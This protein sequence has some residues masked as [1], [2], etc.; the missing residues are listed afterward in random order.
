MKRR[1]AKADRTPAARRKLVEIDAET[2]HGLDLLARD[3]FATFQ[4][5]ADEAFRDLLI[6]HHRP[7]T[8]R[9]ALRQSVSEPAIKHRGKAPS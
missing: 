5:L 3:R 4:E 9:D 7:V 6:K 2:W 8:L 1:D